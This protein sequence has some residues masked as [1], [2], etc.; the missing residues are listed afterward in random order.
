MEFSTQH[1][2][3]LYRKA[4]NHT[5]PRVSSYPLMW[6]DPTPVLTLVSI[7]LAFVLIGKKIMQNKPEV[8]V[9]S[10]ILIVY[11]FFLVLLSLYMFEEVII[12]VLSGHFANSYLLSFCKNRLSSESYN[13]ITIW[14]ALMFEYLLLEK[15]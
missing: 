14:Y 3:D 15:K 5:D 8:K 7:Y 10:L 12:E 11:N 6:N 4:L 13:L 1:M 2:L 9:P